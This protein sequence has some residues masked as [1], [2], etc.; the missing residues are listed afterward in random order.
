VKTVTS[1]CG[2]GIS[3]GHIGIDVKA[4]EGSKSKT[5][6]LLL[7]IKPITHP[8]NEDTGRWED[9]TYQ[10]KPWYPVMEDIVRGLHHKLEDVL[11]PEV[12]DEIW[13]KH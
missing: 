6:M 2:H 1:C 12:L 3:Q 9:E 4:I 7:D 10:G 8:Y 13:N 5:K 11:A